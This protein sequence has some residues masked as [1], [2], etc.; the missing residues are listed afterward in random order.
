M[1]NP[2]LSNLNSNLNFV[3]NRL[4]LLRC[5]TA[6]LLLSFVVYLELKN[7]APPLQTWFIL[8]GYIPLLVIGF[9]QSRRE[10]SSN[11]LAF[12][13]LFETQLITLFLYFTGGAG[14]PLISYFLVLV[15][16]A[17]Y[18]L[19]KIWVWLIATACIIDYTILTQY[20]LPLESVMPSHHL[21]GNSGAQ[22]YLIYWHLAGMWLTFVIS[23]IALSLI[24]PALME[25]SIKKRLQ[26]IELR[27][28]QLKNEQLI[29]IA[30]LAAGTAHEMGTPLMTMEMLL[31]DSL[32]YQF[33]IK[34]EDR[35][36]LHQQVMI[37]RQALQRLS[38]AG[39]DIHNETQYIN[40]N[41]WLTSL[42]HRWRLSQP[43]AMW[44]NR[45]FELQIEIRK[46]PLLDQALL[47]LLDNASQAGSESIELSSE[48][49]DKQWSLTIHQPDTQA[50]EHLQQH[51]LFSSNKQHGVGLGLYL[52]NAS[53]E[54]FDGQVHL[55][56][57][58]DGSTTCIISLPCKSHD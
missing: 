39:R 11:A 19:K 18:N 45:G 9:I 10:L 30:T 2:A 53:I 31:N 6:T 37:C 17:A 29:G 34:Q 48:V 12:H 13:L 14:N 42:L 43:N 28:K 26:L 49:I 54:Q 1:Q 23:T 4:T 27:E 32:E 57:N 33:D 22:G 55:A 58:R 44:S 41:Q 7:F 51:H 21:A 24:I 35:K 40:A 15:V 52:S 50:A 47:N 8:A 5:V 20:Y 46:S 25:D 56:A 3:L 16:I 38:L 36:L